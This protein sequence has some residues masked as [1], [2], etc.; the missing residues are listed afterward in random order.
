MKLFKS[1]TCLCAVL[2]LL[3]VLTGCP[4]SAIKEEPKDP[5][6]MVYFTFFDT[7]SYI[8]SYAEDENEVFQAN[9]DEVATILRNITA[10]STFT[11]STPV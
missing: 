1:L 7:V 6:G 2:G 9:C 10:F 5:L 4:N 3:V 11:M 8:Y